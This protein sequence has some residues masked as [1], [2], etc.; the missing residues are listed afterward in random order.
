M[1]VAPKR[2]KPGKRRIP[3][4]C[5]CCLPAGALGSV[6]TLCRAPRSRGNRGQ[7][8]RVCAGGDPTGR[9][10]PARLVGRIQ[11]QRRTWTACDGQ[12]REG[13]WGRSLHPPLIDHGLP[14]ADVRLVAWLRRAGR[15]C[16]EQQQGAEEA[17]HRSPSLSMLHPQHGHGVVPSHVHANSSS[18]YKTKIL[19]R[20]HRGQ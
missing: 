8:A 19:S 10:W 5:R 1:G 2:C 12:R 13:Q 11:S 6:C 7:L 16:D 17:G 4:R 18:V 15:Q 14:L 20:S 3:A 9:A